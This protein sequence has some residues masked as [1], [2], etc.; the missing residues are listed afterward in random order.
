VNFV[1]LI[2]ILSFGVCAFLLRTRGSIRQFLGV[3]GIFTGAFIAAYVYGLLAFLTGDS[4]LRVIILAAVMIG[5]IFLTYDLGLF[6]GSIIQ[7]KTVLRA[8]KGTLADKGLAA[9]FSGLI[10]TSVLW[11]IVIFFQPVFPPSLQNTV[12]TSAILN[13]ASSSIPLPKDIRAIGKLVK[14]FQAPDVFV[15]EEPDLSGS[16]GV[17]TPIAREYEKLDASIKKAASSIA[18]IT[19]WGCGAVANG[20]GFLVEPTL[21]ATN[22]H[23]VAGTEKLTVEINSKTLVAGVAYFNPKLD[24]AVIR[25]NTPLTAPPLKLY[26][27]ALSPGTIAAVLGFPGGGKFQA[28]DVTVLDKLKARGKDIYNQHDVLRQVYAVRGDV[29]PGN[30]GGP[31]ITTE[32]K[33]AGVIFG[34]STT[35]HKT[36][37]AITSDQ[38]SSGIKTAHDQEGATASG[39]CAE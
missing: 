19:S 33:V 16:S 25:T 39:S 34:H 13:M 31:I 3:I 20:S 21:I 28:G 15:G 29:V 10:G 27:K 22:A 12:K 11:L 36:G 9:L 35:S 23:V 32:G 1:D 6:L 18:K 24:F 4:V 8:F 5:T 17:T 37:Y 7:K 26:D 14:P 38:L 30:S 2:F